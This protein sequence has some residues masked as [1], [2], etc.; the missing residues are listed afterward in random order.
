M[1]VDMRNVGGWTL[2]L[3]SIWDMRAKLS[4][5]VRL[6]QE[7]ARNPGIAGPNRRAGDDQATLFTA[8]NAFLTGWHMLDWL[9]FHAKNDDLWASISAAAGCQITDWTTLKTWVLTHDQ[10]RIC[11]AICVATKHVSVNDKEL[12]DLNFDVPVHFDFFTP[13]SLAD[14]PMY[15]VRGVLLR[16]EK[17]GI[18]MTQTVANALADVENWWDWLLKEA[19]VPEYGPFIP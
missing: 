3:A 9:T 12:K 17:G 7:Q 13:K 1:N 2:G 18:H 10:M 11:L 14:G 5:E 19:Q 8:M 4:W 15:V 6:F 16:T